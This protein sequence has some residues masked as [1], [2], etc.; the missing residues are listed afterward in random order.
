VV[1]CTLGVLKSDSKLAKL[2]ERVA[3]LRALFSASQMNHLKILPV[4][5]TALRYEQV[6]AE[7]ED[8]KRSGIVVLTREHI[9]KLPEYALRIPDGDRYFEE[10]EQSLR[11][12][13]F[14]KALSTT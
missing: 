6:K 3:S 8:A 11:I 10:A 1:E 12:D 5:V 14:T 4:I 13:P 2:A 7:A 9:D